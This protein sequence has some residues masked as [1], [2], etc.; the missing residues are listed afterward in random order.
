MGDANPCKMHR[1]SSAIAVNIAYGHKV[2]DEGDSY[3]T[4][5]DTAIQGITKAGVYGSFMVDYIPFLK[6]VPAWMP[7][8]GFQRKA[9]EWRR[10]SSDMRNLPFDVVKRNSVGRLSS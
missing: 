6:H 1:T 10:L 5:A 7:G 3:V 2:A 8:A 9:Q 4:L